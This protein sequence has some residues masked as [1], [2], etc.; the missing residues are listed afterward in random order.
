MPTSQGLQVLLGLTVMKPLSSPAQ[1]DVKKKKGW[2][3]VVQFPNFQISHLTF[4]ILL[5]D[6]CLNYFKMLKCVI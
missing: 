4:A 5:L 6:T 1:E 2:P 3:Y